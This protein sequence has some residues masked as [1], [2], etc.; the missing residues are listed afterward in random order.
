MRLARVGPAGGHFRPVAAP[1]RWRVCVTGEFGIEEIEIVVVLSIGVFGRIVSHVAPAL[2][3]SRIAEPLGFTVRP[4]CAW[5]ARRGRD[6]GAVCRTNRYQVAKN[7]LCGG[8]KSRR[9]GSIQWK[10]ENSKESTCSSIM[11]LCTWR[12]WS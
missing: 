5:P 1:V 9:R 10:G 2:R 11:R 7:D 6:V 3:F 8:R 4:L 12:I